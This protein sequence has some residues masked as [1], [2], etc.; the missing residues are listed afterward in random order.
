[1]NRFKKLKNLLEV[2]QATRTMSGATRAYKKAFTDS[3]KGGERGGKLQQKA[4]QLRQSGTAIANIHSDTM[5]KVARKAGRKS[6]T[7]L[8]TAMRLR[9]LVPQSRSRKLTRDRM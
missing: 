6:M 7:D 8:H 9:P 2:S 1:M 3:W 4:H 5:V